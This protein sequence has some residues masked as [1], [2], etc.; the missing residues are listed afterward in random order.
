VQLS[1]TP[2]YILLLASELALEGPR[3]SHIS[4]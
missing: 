3:L 4:K 1:V 2:N